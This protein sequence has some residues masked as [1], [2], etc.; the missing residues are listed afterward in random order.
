MSLLPPPNAIGAPQQFTMWRPHQP[1]AILRAIETDKRFW[2][3]VM[4]TGSGKSLTVIG[5]ALLA[6]WRTLVLTSTKGL[7]S[8]YGESFESIGLVDVRGKNA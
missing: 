2:A 5:A 1:K 3:G 8:Q 4:P 7:Q 6:G